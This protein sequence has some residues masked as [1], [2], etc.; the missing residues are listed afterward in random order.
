MNDLVKNK[1]HIP[2]AATM[3]FLGYFHFGQ[4][5]LCNGK[6]FVAN[7]KMDY[8]ENREPHVN[9]MVLT[10]LYEIETDNYSIKTILGDKTLS[11]KTIKEWLEQ[12]CDLNYE[13]DNQYSEVI[14]YLN[15]YSKET[16]KTDR[17]LFYSKKD[18]D[19]NITNNI[20][21]YDLKN[22][23]EMKLYIPYKW[24]KKEQKAVTPTELK[25]VIV[26]D[27]SGKSSVYQQRQCR[28]VLRHPKFRIFPQKL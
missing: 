13:I 18:K 12:P 9:T 3:F 6:I 7:T 4:V 20:Y 22:Q 28:K 21:A 17:Y 15:Q 5:F 19:Y 2:H 24:D 16:F 11:A 27:L 14:K 23:A 25:D 26:E 8:S 10:E 1:C